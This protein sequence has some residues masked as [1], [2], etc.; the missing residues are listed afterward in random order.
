MKLATIGPDVNTR[1]PM[2][3]GS[4][5]AYAAHVSPFWNPP[6]QRRALLGEPGAAERETVV[7]RV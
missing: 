3:Q 7:N 2:I 6:S 4:R 1:K 5:N